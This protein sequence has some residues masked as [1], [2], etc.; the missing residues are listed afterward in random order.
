MGKAV[1]RESQL[2]LQ[3]D[4]KKQKIWQM[5]SQ[6]IMINN[7][8]NNISNTNNKITSDISKNNKYDNLML[9]IKED[10]EKAEEQKKSD[11]TLEQIREEHALFQGDLK[12]MREARE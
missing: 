2:A 9:A 8:T 6:I 1:C 10:E 7:A 4:E 12:A 5:A 11:A 3:A